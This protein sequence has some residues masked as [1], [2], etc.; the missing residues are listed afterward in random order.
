MGTIN[1]LNKESTYKDKVLMC[2][3]ILEIEP[4]N[5]YLCSKAKIVDA[6][7]FTDDYDRAIL[8]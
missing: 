3:H 4:N 7:Y 2:K 1:Y 6:I 5:L 8:C